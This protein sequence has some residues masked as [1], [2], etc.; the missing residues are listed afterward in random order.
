MELIR[1]F[2]LFRWPSFLL[3]II[4][5]VALF[6]GLLVLDYP[7]DDPDT[8]WQHLVATHIRLYGERPLGDTDAHLSPANPFYYKPPY[9]YYL[10]AT[11]GHV[12]DSVMFLNL[13]NLGLQLLVVWIVYR[14][15]RSMFTPGT[16]LLAAA[17]LVFSDLYVRQLSYIYQPHVMQVALAGGWL[18]LWEFHRQGRA[19]HAYIAAALLVLSVSLYLSALVMVPA[20]VLLLWH[21]CRRHGWHPNRQAYLLL[22]AVILLLPGGY[23]ST[24]FR[25]QAA[26]AV[27]VQAATLPVS[28]A[29][30]LDQVRSAV[31]A[32]SRELFPYFPAPP[33]GQIWL[34]C[35]AVLAAVAFG[36]T[37]YKRRWLMLAGILAMG[38]LS[39]SLWNLPMSMR[40]VI[41][42]LVPLVLLLATGLRELTAVSRLPWL[43]LV[44]L[45]VWTQVSGRVWWQPQVLFRFPQQR[46]ITRA[47]G[48]LTTFLRG[49]DLS[50]DRVGFQQLYRQPSGTTAVIPDLTFWTAVEKFYGRPGI[51]FGLDARIPAVPAQPDVIILVCTGNPSPYTVP[52]SECARYYETHTPDRQFLT[53]IYGDDRVSLRAYGR[54]AV[55]SD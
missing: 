50:P 47:A 42:F 11:L 14:L 31:A 32:V 40:Y 23:L 25:L 26:G 41:P 33:A 37:Q 8:P 10:L 15:G 17:L 38:L 3:G 45:L 20:F 53:V 13:V 27:N 12:H 43:A 2:R 4:I 18:C 39:L 24:R 9:Y 52:L 48:E 21:G 29:D 5:G 28:P 44:L 7:L 46:S 49:K 16:G 34:A 22:F 51:S 1:H 30:W 54:A 36:N 19:A 55:A 6:R 35:L